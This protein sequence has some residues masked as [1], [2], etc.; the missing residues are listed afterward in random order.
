MVCPSGDQRGLLSFSSWSEILVSGPPAAEITHTSSFRSPSNSLP[1]RFE[2]KATRVP[3]GDHCGSVSFQ[4]S[5]SVI[6][7]AP[8]DFTSTIHRWVRRSANQPLSFKLLELFFYWRPV[9]RSSG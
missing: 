6:C 7:L 8:P 1:V 9:Y 3:S 2:T 4:S 5:P